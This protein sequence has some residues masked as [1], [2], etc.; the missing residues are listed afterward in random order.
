MKSVV[1]PYESPSA[2]RKKGVIAP[3]STR[4]SQS[5]STML[6][7]SVEAGWIV[8]FESSQ[9]VLVIPAGRRGVQPPPHPV[10]AVGIVQDSR[11]PLVSAANVSASQ[12]MYQFGATSSDAP[13]Q[14]LSIPSQ[15]SSAPS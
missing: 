12:S 7:T 11:L 13:L 5:S 6:H 2:S 4:V 9:S 15:S 1:T 8:R 10:G 14:L 3:S